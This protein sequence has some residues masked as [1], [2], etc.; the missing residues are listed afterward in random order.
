MHH[1]EYPRLSLVNFQIAETMIN[2]RTRVPK[3]ACTWRTKI[4]VYGVHVTFCEIFLESREIQ[5]RITFL[6]HLEYPRLSLVNFQIA[7]TMIKHRTRVPKRACTWEQRYPSM[8][9]HVTFCEIFLESREIQGRITLSAS[10][11]CSLGW[12]WWIFRSLRPW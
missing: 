12:V 3:R 7:E 2:H 10:P 1:L 6:H 11:R 5:G 4:P 9:V 8:G